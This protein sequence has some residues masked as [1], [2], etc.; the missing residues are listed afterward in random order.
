MNLWVSY[1]FTLN[2]YKFLKL[3]GMEKEGKNDK[4]DNE[5]EKNICETTAEN[6]SKGFFFGFYCFRI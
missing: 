1:L 2:V 3:K 6:I 4:I 5:N